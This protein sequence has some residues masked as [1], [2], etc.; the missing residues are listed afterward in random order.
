ME[1]C[2]MDPPEDRRRI[3][4]GCDGCG[5]TIREED[6]FYEQNI[7]GFYKALC[8]HCFENSSK[9]ELL[10]FFDIFETTAEPEID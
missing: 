4:T 3:V 9:E 1:S 5:R 7:N 2:F 6:I 8:M 10:R